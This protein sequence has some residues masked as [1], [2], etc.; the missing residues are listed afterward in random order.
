[1][2]K[3]CSKCGKPVEDGSSFCKNCGA[4]IPYESN[5]AYAGEYYV[6]YRK[7][8]TQTLADRERASAVVWTVVAG[9]Q[10]IIAL[11][12]ISGLS[13]IGSL[14]GIP[15]AWGGLLML[16]LASYNAYGAYCSFRRVK[17]VLERRRGIVWEYDKMLVT[18]IVFIVLNV[19][20]GAVIGV[21]G[22]V[23]DLFNRYYALNN[24]PYLEDIDIKNERG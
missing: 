24:A 4:K 1:M 3:Y 19:I 14:I 18:S 11:L 12:T 6:P 23:F 17:R 13:L 2:N 16:A 5:F 8:P 7:T 15:L 22:A 20:F 21:A 10:G 9:L